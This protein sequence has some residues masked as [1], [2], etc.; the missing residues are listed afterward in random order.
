[1]PEDQRSSRG[2]RQG[3]RDQL[4]HAPAAVLAIIIVAFA[5]DNHQ[6]VTVGFVFTDEKVPLVFVLVATTLIGAAI[7]A[8]LTWRRR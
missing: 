1:M 3:T 7:G 8:L 4:R 6:Q 5:I 2:T